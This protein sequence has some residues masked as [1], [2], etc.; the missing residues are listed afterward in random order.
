MKPE[1][2]S[3]LRRPQVRARTGLS[4]TR[5]DELEAREQ[6]PKRVQISDRAIAWVS[7]EIDGWIHDRIA[8]RDNGGRKSATP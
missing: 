8:L 7:T 1:S 2:T 5:I 3:F 6:F 4:D